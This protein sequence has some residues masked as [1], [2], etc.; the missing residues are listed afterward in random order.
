MTMTGSQ[1]IVSLLKKAG[2]NTVAG[3]PGGSILPL[4]DELCKSTINHVLVRQEQ[5]AGFIAQGIA[6]TTGKVGV[7]LATSGPGAMN[8]LTAIADA[9][10]DSVPIV[11]ITGQVNTSLIG[12]DAFQEAD[13]FGLSFPI[14]KHSVMV[15]SV[16][17]LLT[18]FPKAFAIAQNGRAGPVLI[19]VPR[20][21]QTASIDID[22]LPDM[23]V[24]C[25]A[26]D[27]RFLGLG[28]SI[29]Y[30]TGKDEIDELLEKATELLLAS[31]KPVLYVGG[32]ANT[33]DGARGL[34]R[35]LEVFPCPVATSLMGIGAVPRS[36]IGM[37]G[38]V[39]M[40]GSICANKAMHDSDVIIAAGSRFDDR[41]TGVIEKFCPNAKIIHIDIDA[42]EINKI[43][44]SE[45]SIVAKIEDILPS[46]ASHIVSKRERGEDKFML[47]DVRRKWLDEMEKLHRESFSLEIGSPEKRADGLINPREFIES[48]PDMAIQAGLRMQDII[49]STDVGQH[50]MWAAQYY[51]VE[52]PRHFLTSGSLGTMGFGLPAAI[53][54]AIANRDKRIIC[55]S[56]DGSIMMNVQELATLAELGLAVTVIVFEN[57][58][59]GMVKQQQDFLF[60]KHH[61]ASV[62]KKSPDLLSIAKGFGIDAIDAN[63]DAEW[64]KKAFKVGPHF[65]RVRISKDETV[66]PYVKAGYA[67]IEAIVN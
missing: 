57:G 47:S 66:L 54:A 31:K 2:I 42:A 49:V 29:K 62:F 36:Y 23:P 18:A 34:S 38:M 61:S 22:T 40:H 25:K 41:A 4:Y 43:L 16:G 20:D 32:G 8:L 56:G 65:V 28:D 5:A 58:T 45:I 63:E 12:T 35:F 59:L 48:I 64:H 15:K 24:L 52:L 60:N 3:I 1:I 37:T 6:R 50:Q 67:N 55:F 27:E 53:G 21:V 9:R 30:H 51:P 11:A 19:D 7:C 46:L 39:G 44:D 26:R 10:C 13:T 17:E 14:T 33:E